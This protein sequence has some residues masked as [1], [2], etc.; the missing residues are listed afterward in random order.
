MKPFPRNETARSR[1]LGIVIASEANL[2]ASADVEVTHHPVADV[3]GIGETENVVVKSRFSAATIDRR[4]IDLP[5]GVSLGD[6]AAGIVVEMDRSGGDV[7]NNTP[8]D[9]K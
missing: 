7:G 9:H 8:V 6:G 2:R 4:N 5:S 3:E 1:S